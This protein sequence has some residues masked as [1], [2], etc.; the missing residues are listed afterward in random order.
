NFCVKGVVD[1]YR[2]LTPMALEV[3][4][5]YQ[6]IKTQWKGKNTINVKNGYFFKSLDNVMMRWV[7]LQNGE[8]K[9]T[10]TL[11]SLNLSAQEQNEFSLP[12]KTRMLADNEYQLN[13]YYHL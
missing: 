12:L 1:A 3:K 10:G 5:V 6:H 13:I 8:S 7:L 4:K 11:T 2:N 9:E